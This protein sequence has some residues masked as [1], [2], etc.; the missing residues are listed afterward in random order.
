MED[1]MG[2]TLASYNQIPIRLAWAITIHKS[3]GMTLER[4]EVDLSRTFEKGQGYVALSRLKDLKGLKLTGFNNIALQV[5]SLAYKADIR[6]QELSRQEERI[7]DSA[8]LEQRAVSF[9]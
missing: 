5:D 2:K 7:S 3:Q 1:D 8:E 9:I 6:F 4:A